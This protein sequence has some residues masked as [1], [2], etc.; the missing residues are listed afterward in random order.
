[1]DKLPK[2]L[3]VED[4][5]IILNAL[6]AFLLQQYDVVIA[7]NGRTALDLIRTQKP[8]IILLDLMLPEMNGFEVMTEKNKDSEL[9]RIPVIVLSNLDSKEHIA[10]CQELG[11]VDYLIKETVNFEIIGYKVE[12]A[13]KRK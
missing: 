7:N 8:D 3:L 11:A 6:S 5:P 12:A 4:E 9:A 10:Q 2:V 13:L 1:M